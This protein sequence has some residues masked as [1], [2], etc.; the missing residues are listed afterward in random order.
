MALRI[1]YENVKARAQDIDD[2]IQK[3]KTLKDKLQNVHSNL[4][5]AWQGDAADVFK[6]KLND[7]IS[8]LDK[9]IKEMHSIKRDIL[10]V[11]KSIKETDENLAND[12]SR[13][14]IAF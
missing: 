6:C 10:T 9:T 7:L 14:R 8:E 3:L 4:Q 2:V 1:D 5:Y 13:N 12:I 11:A